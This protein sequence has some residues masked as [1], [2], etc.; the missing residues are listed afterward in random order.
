M[1]RPGSKATKRA[2]TTGVIVAIARSV[3]RTL[4]V[5]EVPHTECAAYTIYRFV[6]AWARLRK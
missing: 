3:G 4:R 1:E 5:R 2:M 6:V